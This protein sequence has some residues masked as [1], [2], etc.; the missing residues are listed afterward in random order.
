L[1]RDSAW[2]QLL[3]ISWTSAGIHQPFVEKECV[4]VETT[5]KPFTLHLSFSNAVEIFQMSLFRG[6][7]WLAMFVIEVLI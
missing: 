4:S 6:L 3:P 5:L 7:S 1:K 2:W